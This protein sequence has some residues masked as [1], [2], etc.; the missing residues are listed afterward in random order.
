[1]NPWLPIH[2]PNPQ[3]VARLFCFHNIGGKAADFRFLSPLLPRVEIMAVQLSSR[4]Q[5]FSDFVGEAHRALGPHCD[6]LPFAFF[7]YSFGSLLAY[8]LACVLEGEG[9]PPSHL[10]VSSLAAPHV[11][12]QPGEA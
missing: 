3:A 12:R 9:R 6:G 11:L 4:A 2:K 8:E 10:V 5:V 7:G 1:M